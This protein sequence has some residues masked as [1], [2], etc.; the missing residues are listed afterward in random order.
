[1]EGEGVKKRS[2]REERIRKG[3]GEERIGVCF[4]ILCYFLQQTSKIKRR[5]TK[6]FATVKKHLQHT[7]KTLGLLLLMLLMVLMMLMLLMLMWMLKYL[8]ITFTYFIGFIQRIYNN[9]CNIRT[10]T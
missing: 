4:F 7:K 1:M 6:L 2:R 8:D 3:E 9:L 10:L 5:T